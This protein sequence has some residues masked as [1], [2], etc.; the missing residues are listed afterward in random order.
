VR[1]YCYCALASPS[2]RSCHRDTSDVQQH[3]VRPAMWFGVAVMA[4]HGQLYWGSP[5][6]PRV[7][8]WCAHSH[9]IDSLEGL[10]ELWLPAMTN[11]AYRI[12]LWPSWATEQVV[13]NTCTS[14]S[15]KSFIITIVACTMYS[16]HPLDVGGI[17][18]LVYKQCIH[19]TWVEH[20]LMHNHYIHLMCACA[21]YVLMY[22]QCIHS[23]WVQ[24]IDSL[25]MRVTP[26]LVIQPILILR[27]YTCSSTASVTFN[28]IMHACTFH[29]NPVAN[30]LFKQCVGWLSM[31]NRVIVVVQSILIFSNVIMY[32]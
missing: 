18:V 14:H 25:C 4:K 12:A 11:G 5:C 27:K 30:R 24:H 13:H 15:P 21:T 26:T 2:D 23:M 8:W 7:K 22:N 19:S 29:A 9:L 20:I 16:M 3:I 32:A 28:I 17:Y 1:L 31:H 10:R 6:G